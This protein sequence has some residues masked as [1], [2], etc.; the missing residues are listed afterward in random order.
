[1]WPSTLLCPP[2]PPRLVYLD[3]NHWIGLAK[4]HAGHAD[5]ARHEAVLEECLGAR[6]AGD[7]VFPISD[8]IFIEAGKI[9]PYRQ[10][11]DL[12][13][14]IEAVSGFLVVTG[15]F[16]I[17]THEVEAMLDQL[18]GP[19]RRPMNLMLYLDWGV[20]R[21]FGL[22]GGFTVHGEDGSDITEEARVNWPGGP[23]AFDAALGAA[24]LELCRKVLEGPSPEAEPEL[25][26]LGWDPSGSV[27]IAERRAE[28]EI[29]QVARLNDDTRWR[30]G[31]IRDVVAAREVLIEINRILFEGMAD[32]DASLGDYFTGPEVARR[33]FDAMPS[34]DVAVTIK[35]EYHRDLAHR[36]TPNDVHDV[37]AI[38]S[39]LPYCDVVV[40]D[41]AVASHATR[42]GLADRLGT[43]VLSWLDDLNEL[44]SDWLTVEQ[45]VSG[46][47]RGDAY[48]TTPPF[49]R[50][51]R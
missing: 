4:A 31:R 46:A 19:S 7:A 12:R 11:R 42:S 41:K 30:R 36:W 6:A 10:R 43:I 39:T 5:G 16:V 23:E 17:A 44:L 48:G 29:E 27:V 13:E 47:T 1:M 21:A 51:E 40:T 26:D 45:P 8:A 22:A 28:Q 38:G 37:D 20:A 32:R 9:G 14:V 34:F 3:L 18:V 33:N 2:R 49:A 24:E 15:R 35:T 25:R 50:G